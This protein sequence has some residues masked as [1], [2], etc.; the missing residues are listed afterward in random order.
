MATPL[1]TNFARSTLSAGIT[2]VAT[3]LSVAAGT[4]ALFPSPG[5]GEYFP[6]VVVRV[7]DG[8][9]EV[10]YC[11]SRTVDTLTV[12][13]AQEGTTGLV[14]IS[15]DVCG[16]RITAASMT[17]ITALVL[18]PAA[19]EVTVASVAGTTNIGAAAS[20]SVAIS[21]VNAITAFDTVASG[22]KRL[23][24]ATGAFSL[25]HS[26]NLV[27]P[28]GADITA[29]VGDLFWTETIGGGVWYIGPYQCAAVA[30]PTV[31]GVA[32]VPKSADYTTTLGDAG[33]SIDHPATDANAR[34]F[35]IN[36]A[37]AYP[38]GTCITFSNMS[39][40]N[41]T[42]AISTDTLYLA[43]A[44]S[45]GSR[46]LAQYGQATARKVLAGVWLISGPGLS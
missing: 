9:K 33:L 16:N 10:M 28:G 34:T 46:T 18:S 2:N 32:S 17:D 31:P 26:A 4:G 45:T 27:C 6:F 43:G 22:T 7:S 20:M 29:A 1:F 13:R 36:G 14:F 30:T 35:T 5:A 42:I 12:T 37:V 8:A 40:N 19:A 39:A 44:G 41:V 25:V 3:S 21:G 24:R 23:I 11:T 38:A 15:G